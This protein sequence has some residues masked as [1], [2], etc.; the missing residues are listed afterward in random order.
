MA[1]DR[2]SVLL[3]ANDASLSSVI[4]RAGSTVDEFGNRVDKSGR[5]VASTTTMMQRS[6]S[7]LGKDIEQGFNRSIRSFAVAATGAYVAGHALNA[8]LQ[9]LIGG[10]VQFQARMLNVN[11]ISHLSAQSLA[12]LSH[13][14]LD[15]SRTLPTSAN[16]LAS[17]LYDIASSGF[18]GAAG[19][20]VLTAS[21]K[22]A[23]A[24]LTDTA[25]SARAIAGVLNAYGLSAD[26]AKNVSDSLFQTVNVGVL[27]FNDLAQG[28]GQ[29]VGTAAAAGV[30]VDQLGAAIATMT[31]AG[32][33][34]A[35]AFTSLNQV[36]AQ[37]IQPSQT[38]SNL[39][40][41]LHYTSGAA[42]LQAKGLAGVMQDIQRATG[43]NVTTMSELFTDIR[44]LR[45]AMALTTNQG[46]LYTDS[47]REQNKAHQGAGATATTL[48]VQLQSVSAQWQILKNRAE[49]AAITFGTALLPTLNA[50]IHGVEIL[51]QVIATD[52]V[53]QTVEFATAVIGLNVA[54]RIM[55]GI[56][57]TEIVA[58]LARFVG[59]T[60]AAAGASSRLTLAIN[61][62]G[63]FGAI[64]TV[65]FGVAEGAIALDRA[66]QPAA[67]DVDKLRNSLV[68]LEQEG[69]IAGELP[70]AFG[71]NLKDLGSEIRRIVDPSVLGRAGDTI[72]SVLSFGQF[73]GSGQLEEARR[74]LGSLDKALAT[75]VQGGNGD[76]AKRTFNDLAAAANAQGVSTADLSRVLPKYNQALEDGVTAGK[77]SAEG[78]KQQ[79]AAL[80]EVGAAAQA[81]QQ[82]IDQARAAAASAFSGSF[83]VI[84]QFQPGKGAEAVSAAQ[85]KLLAAQK[86]LREEQARYDAQKHHSVSSD[87]E[88][89]HA[90]D[91]VTTAT[92]NLTAAQRAAGG[93]S[94]L[95]KIYARDLQ[96]GRQ[97]VTDI[98]AL[99]KRGLDPAE[100]QRLL[101]AGPEQAGGLAH[102]LASDKSGKLIRLSNQNERALAQLAIRASNL[103]Q[104][105]LDQHPVFITVGANLL[106]GSRG[107]QPLGDSGRQALPAPRGSSP[108]VVVHSGGTT[109]TRTTNINVGTVQAPDP[110]GFL[111]DLRRRERTRRAV[112]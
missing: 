21:A 98:R 62:M 71:A 76:A 110:A 106:P 12:G 34:P 5:Q 30:S 95:Q 19:V 61:G 29:V 52:G 53:R 63:R 102:A 43:G 80:D 111:R 68:A 8:G 24:G 77:L 75:L 84:G 20:K 27:S 87:Q 57:G 82:K 4:R 69:R 54:L 70:K 17:G 9:D 36:L 35:E 3:E 60:S 44:A 42:A 18:Q 49:A 99:L 67:P 56:A 46:Q 31:R 105:T 88:L 39:F 50:L 97:F 45:G 66:M 25:T 83:N 96:Q 47:I 91:K 16:D 28:I 37:I 22:A 103:M 7:G 2:L 109:T 10:A 6:F 59:A 14:V 15:L 55:R 64:G 89:A 32:I 112:L 90:R 58:G 78:S 104:R 94:S 81:A 11:S 79:A 92:R 86:G 13:N 41:K 100:V 72:S 85:D 33:V 107:G 108:V 40:D 1:L 101:S 73:G 48:A 65:L 26:Q 51:G 23:T 74:D 38:L 93:E